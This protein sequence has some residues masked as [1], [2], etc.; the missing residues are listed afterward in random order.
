MPYSPSDIEFGL[1]MGNGAITLERDTHAATSTGVE[2]H[3]A[4][5]GDVEL[6]FQLSGP[7]DAPRG[8]YVSGSGSDLRRQPN[9]SS[10]SVSE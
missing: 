7:L 9:A 5:I 8:L 10:S 4:R 2:E 3:R 6:T 1:G